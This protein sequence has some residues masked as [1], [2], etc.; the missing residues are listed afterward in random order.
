M[1]AMTQ[2]T[3]IGERLR[4][5]IEGRG[6]KHAWV[7]IEAGVTPATLSNIL[8]GR[9]ADPS[10]S[11][12]LA[13]ARTIG[14]PIAAIFDEPFQPLLDSEQQVLRQA[15]DILERRILHSP[16]QGFAASSSS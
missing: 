2:G 1:C 11:V 5:A 8:T 6:M 7:A 9:T 14:Q 4:A 10:F 3:T 15:V 13:I 16:A 12:V